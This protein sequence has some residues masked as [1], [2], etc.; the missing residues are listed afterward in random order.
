M[1]FRVFVVTFWAHF[2]RSISGRALGRLFDPKGAKMELPRGV[3]MQSDHA[4]ACFVKVGRYRLGSIS[5]SIFESFSEP[6]SLLYSFLVTL[7]AQRH[8]SGDP[9]G[10]QEPPKPALTAELIL[11]LSSK[12]MTGQKVMQVHASSCK[13]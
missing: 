4:C 13:Y 5:G 10:V 7:V 6:S 3:H 8:V 11:N 2:F 9:F 12:P 1:F